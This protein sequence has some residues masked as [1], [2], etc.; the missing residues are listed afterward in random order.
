M[1]KKIVIYDYKGIEK[2]QVD[3]KI[4]DI[5]VKNATDM[6][7]Q[8][9]RV[10]LFNKRQGTSKVKTRSNVRGGGKKP[11]KQKGTGRA[12]AGTI[13]SPLWRGGGIIHGPI[14]KNWNLKLQKRVKA[15]VFNLAVA[16]KLETGNILAFEFPSKSK[17]STKD[18]STFLNKVKLNGK[19]LVLHINDDTL[20][21]SF[22]N[23]KNISVK[24]ISNVSAF[25]FLSA[26]NVLIE[27]NGISELSK[28]VA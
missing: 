25:D 26:S 1:K 28:K 3:L 8:Y 13:R 9:I 14:P 17:I 21:K 7:S 24:N 20:Y 5:K 18:A 11:W 2:K 23:I 19:V 4:P 22:R 15:K 10:F 16:K 27:S 6:I 12:R